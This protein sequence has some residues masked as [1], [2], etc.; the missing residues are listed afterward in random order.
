[1]SRMINWLENCAVHAAAAC[2]TIIMLIVSADAMARYLLD[3]PLSWTYEVI[4]YYLLAAALYLA[5]ASTFSGGDHISI[6][7]FRGLLPQKLRNMFE[8]V[9]GIMA[10]TVFAL[11]AF[12]SAKEMLV[13]FS[14]HEFLPGYIP[15]PAWASYPPIVFGTLM[16]TL[17]LLS[18]CLVLAV[19][20]EDANVTISEG[21]AE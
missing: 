3:S 2:V 14:E 6:S 5:I 19:W 7:L 13:A 12:Y 1:M 9:W 18:H 4:V 8:I 11:I 21:H 10:A 17:R 16:L 20:G 15:W